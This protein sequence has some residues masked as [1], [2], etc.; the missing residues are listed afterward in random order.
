MTDQAAT[1]N[2][3]AAEEAVQVEGPLRKP[4]PDPAKPMIHVHRVV[5]KIDLHP[6]LTGVAMNVRVEANVQL[7]IM[8]R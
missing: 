3:V 7:V 5:T 6:D 8:D 4:V 1:G 2:P